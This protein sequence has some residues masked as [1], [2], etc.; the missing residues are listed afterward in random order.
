MS[1]GEV[2]MLDRAP[3]RARHVGL[4]GRAAA[5]ALSPS[6][7]TARSISAFGGSGHPMLNRSFSGFDP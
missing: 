3:R 7:R 5:G 4:G 6:D 2:M 1:L